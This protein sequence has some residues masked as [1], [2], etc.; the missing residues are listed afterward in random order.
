MDGHLF[1]LT[2]VGPQQWDIHD[3]NIDV[4]VEL[5]GGRRFVATFFTLQNIHSLFNK[6]LETGECSGG[7]YLWAA[8]MILVKDLNLGTISATISSLLIDG[9]FN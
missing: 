7:L 1:K 4:E 5:P 8:D 6:N 2:V 3:D 9:E